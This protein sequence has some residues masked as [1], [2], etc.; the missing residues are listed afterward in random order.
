MALPLCGR[1][2]GVRIQKPTCKE[3]APV[4]PGEET[5]HRFWHPVG[6]LGDSECLFSL[7][8]STDELVY[9]WRRQAIWHEFVHC[10][11]PPPLSFVGQQLLFHCWPISLPLI[12]HFPDPH[13]DLPPLP[14]ILRTFTFLF[15]SGLLLTISE[16]FRSSCS[17][18]IL[19][20]CLSWTDSLS[21]LSL[22]YDCSLQNGSYRSDTRQGCPVVPSPKCWPP[23]LWAEKMVIFKPLSFE[24]F[25][26]SNRQLIQPLLNEWLQEL[27]GDVQR[28]PVCDEVALI[29]RKFFMFHWD[30][31]ELLPTCLNS[32]FMSLTT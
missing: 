10:C 22:A 20:T 24:I 21:C 32:V 2:T 31:L 6:R 16:R 4:H 12:L 19:L 3:P 11:R 5:P 7:L 30:L 28:W 26:G 23:E 29:I 1:V 25:V 15:S 9:L 17:E 14:L 18:I 27:E 13:L 8:L